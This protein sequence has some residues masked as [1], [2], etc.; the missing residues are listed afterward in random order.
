MPAAKGKG[1]TVVKPTPRPR[2]PAPDTSSTRAQAGSTAPSEIILPKFHSLPNHVC[3]NPCS[4]AE[5]SA[6]E[7]QSGPC[8]RS[9]LYIQAR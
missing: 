3:R 8:T 4:S 6:R 9:G 1:K 2:K 5:E 7:A